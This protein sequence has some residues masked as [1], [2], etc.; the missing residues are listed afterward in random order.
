MPSALS[1]QL[2][3]LGIVPMCSF[4]YERMFNTT[5]IPGIETGNDISHIFSA[6][7]TTWQRAYSLDGFYF[8][9]RHHGFSHWFVHAQISCSIWRTGS[10]WLCTIKAVSLKCGCTMVVATFGPRSLSCSFNVSWM[11]SLNLNLER[12]SSLHWLL[13]TGEDELTIVLSLCTWVGSNMGSRRLQEG[14]Q[15]VWTVWLSW[16]EPI[17]K[18]FEE[19]WKLNHFS[20]H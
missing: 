12:S 7:Y 2:R 14:V 13:G 18:Y 6:L 4:Q 17:R 20:C 19:C 16:V 11:T 10:T 5:R 1:Y 9:P 3:A 15:T 8:K